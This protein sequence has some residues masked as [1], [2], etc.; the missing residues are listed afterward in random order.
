MFGFGLMQY[1]WYRW[2]RCVGGSR[3]FKKVNAFGTATTY[4]IIKG[5]ELDQIL[6]G[7]LKDGFVEEWPVTPRQNR[8]NFR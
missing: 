8:N 4:V 7:F 1:S 2:L 3:S 6:E 5:K